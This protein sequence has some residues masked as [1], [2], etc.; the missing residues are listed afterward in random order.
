[1]DII[2]LASANGDTGFLPQ[3]HDDNDDFFEPRSDLKTSRPTKVD[4]RDSKNVQTTPYNQHWLG[5]CTAN[6]I[7]AALR[8]GKNFEANKKVDQN[9]DPA[10]FFLYWSER[11]V[12]ATYGTDVNGTNFPKGER[13]TPDEIQKFLTALKDVADGKSTFKDTDTIN[14]VNGG[15]WK[16]SSIFDSIKGDKGAFER[17]GIKC[18]KRFG[19]CK[20]DT[21]KYSLSPAELTT[22]TQA[23]QD[24]EKAPFLTSKAYFQPPDNALSD[25][26]KYIDT[27]FDYFRI[28]DLGDDISTNLVENMECALAE[29]YPIIMAFRYP[30]DNAKALDD[31]NLKDGVFDHLAEDNQPYYG[32]AVLCIGYDTTT[33]PKR[34]TI[35]NSWGDWG[36]L[37]GYFYLPYNRFQKEN[38]LFDTGNG[39][40]AQADDLWVIKVHK[41]S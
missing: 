3:P 14:G 11:I 18:L 41:S 32:H 15:K 16:M 28:K 2:G 38:A 40:L 21:W 22:R 7:C 29:G 39:K 27:N 24:Q 13:F 35:L 4:L 12:L 31:K 37:H 30:R 19:V 1:M 5:S 25:A 36:P 20:E 23:E 8:F 6:A 9:Y 17:D 33:N 34:F 10:R 26:A